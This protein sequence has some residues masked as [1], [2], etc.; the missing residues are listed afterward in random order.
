[1]EET[2]ETVSV[3]PFSFPHIVTIY[4]GVY[5]IVVGFRISIALLFAFSSSCQIAIINTCTTM[6]R[7]EKEI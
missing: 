1:V 7:P 3:S 6:L 2:E 4:S 5:L